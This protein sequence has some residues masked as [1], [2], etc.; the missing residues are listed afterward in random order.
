MPRRRHVFPAVLA[1]AAAVAA[2]AGAPAGDAATSCGKLVS[3]GT[4][5]P[6]RVVS[7]DIACS[8]AVATLGAF[9]DNG[10][11]PDGWTCARGHYGDP[12]AAHCARNPNGDVVVEA[13]NPP[14]LS[15]PASVRRGKRLSVIGSGLIGGRYTLTVVSDVS[16]ARGVRCLADVGRAR[17]TSGGWV[18]LAGTVPSRL[19]CYQGLNTF[20]GRV[21][22][23]AGRYHVVV[24][25]K[26]SPAGWSGSR[27]YLRARLRVR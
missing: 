9:L 18:T 11:P 27:S 6:V 23:P 25:V 1:A 5:Y 24:G 4:R 20:L 19:R 16:P 15:S 12:Y 13:R 7:G 3:G 8:D 2:L 26:V 17:R 14:D 22:A 21:P 10:V